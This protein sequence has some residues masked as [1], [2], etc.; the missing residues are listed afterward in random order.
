MTV[1]RATSVYS[2]ISRLDHSGESEGP[3][4]VLELYPRNSHT[5][6]IGTYPRTLYNAES[7]TSFLNP[8]H[9]SPQLLILFPLGMTPKSHRNRNSG[10]LTKRS[11]IDVQSKRCKE[12]RD[13]DRA[14]QVPRQRDP[15]GTG[16]QTRE[17][18]PS[19]CVRQ[20]LHPDL[21]QV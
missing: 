11:H 4:M 17:A 20:S 12:R 15:E 19:P 21:N 7:Q 14:T 6:T 5:L 13:V 2:K 1:V 16:Y 10:I 3:S 9:L 18:T 8:T